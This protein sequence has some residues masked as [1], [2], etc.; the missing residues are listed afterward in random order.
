MPRVE[1]KGDNVVLGDSDTKCAY[2]IQESKAVQMHIQ[3][4]SVQNLHNNNNKLLDI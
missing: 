1:Y 3:T 2:V 4:G